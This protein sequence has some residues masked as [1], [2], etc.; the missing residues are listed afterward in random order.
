ML[1]I[2]RSQDCLNIQLISFKFPS[3]PGIGLIPTHYPGKAQM[4]SMKGYNAKYASIN[5]N[6]CRHNNARQFLCMS[7]RETCI[8]VYEARSTS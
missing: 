7:Y 8:E 1:K 5:A 2:Q 3:I 6:E 4:D